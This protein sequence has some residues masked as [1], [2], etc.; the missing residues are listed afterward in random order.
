MKRLVQAELSKLTTTRTFWWTMATTVAFAPL[1]VL[2]A[3]DGAT[4]DAPLDSTEGF[5]NAIGSGASGGVLM[6]VIVG[7]LAVA[8]EFRF[9]TITT[10]FLITPH[11]QQVIAAKLAATALVGVAVAL[12]SS[13]VTLATALP[14]LDDRGVGLA[15]H[16]GDTAIVLLGAA[17]SLAIAALFGV[18][19]G[20]IITNQTAA[21]TITLVWMFVIEGPISTFATS[22]GRWL[23]GGASSAS[24]G[25]ASATGTLLPMWAGALVFT[26][27]ALAF[28]AIGARLLVRKDIA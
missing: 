27:Y 9:N 24:S 23:P 13:A 11:R 19:I 26:A 18:G 20:S 2:L 4:S 10:T 15:G 1:G 12:V 25:I 22:V 21:I 16:V 8:G 6:M 5:R 17:A 14:L 28:A 7:V 3:I